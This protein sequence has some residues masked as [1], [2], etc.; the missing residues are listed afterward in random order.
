MKVV[1]LSVKIKTFGG[2]VYE[3]QLV[4]LKRVSD[5][6]E[7]GRYSVKMKTKDGT[8]ILIRYVGWDCIEFGQYSVHVL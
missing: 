7:E 3:G 2:E 4:K 6:D 5:I 1:S 8:E